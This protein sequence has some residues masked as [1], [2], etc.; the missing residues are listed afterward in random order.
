M[1]DILA[2]HRDD[3]QF[4]PERDLKAIC[5]SPFVVGLHTVTSACAIMIYE[6]L[7]HPKI[8]ARARLEADALFAGEGV[9]AQKLRGIDVIH[10]V[11]QETLRMYP[12]A[13]AL[14][15]EVV[16]TFNF[17][18][19][20]LPSGTQCLIAIAVPH[21]LPEFYPEAGTIRHRPLCGAP[22]RASGAGRVRAVWTGHASLSRQRIL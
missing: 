5:L 2:H 4:L 19:H 15:R 17:A 3:P 8:L 13:T 14:P 6:L 18:G 21:S 12:S 10:R 20:T 11:A 16:N 22:A 1:D 7:K 9:T